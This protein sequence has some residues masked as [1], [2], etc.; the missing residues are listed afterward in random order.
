V[1]GLK[2]CLVIFLFLAVL[3]LGILLISIPL[4]GGV[5][6]MQ[7]NQSGSGT[8][9]PTAGVVKAA[10]VDLYAFA[11]APAVAVNEPYIT[12]TAFGD[13]PDG[14][15]IR[16]HGNINE[17]VGFTCDSTPCQLSLSSD[18]VVSF[19]AYT[20]VGNTSQEYSAVV[21]VSEPSVGEYT[22]TV[23]TSPPEKVYS[24]SC[25]AI[26]GIPESQ[27]PDWAGMTSNPSELDTNETLYLLA[28]SLIQ[29]GVV[30]VSACP[31]GGMANGSPDGCGMEQARKAMVA[32]Q[33]KFDLDIW[34][35]SNAIGIPPKLL[36]TL[37]M[38]ES[39]F[40][41][42]NAQYVMAEIGLA[43]INDQG[44]DVALRWDP[45]LY[46]EICS[47][48]LSDCN[49]PYLHLPE[50]L[51]AM[52]RG[53]LLNQL[54]AQCPTCKYGLNVE[55]AHTS[56]YTIARVLHANCWD[57]YYALQQ[58]KVTAASYEDYW[59]LTLVSYHSGFYCLDSAVAATV[60]AGE[61]IDWPNVSQHLICPGAALY[62]DNFWN[63]LATF[64]NKVI[65]PNP[66]ESVSANLVQES[67]LVP[68]ATPPASSASVTPAISSASVIVHVYV[69][70]N[71]NGIPD[72]SEGVSGVSVELTL[73]NG[74]N[75]Y[76]TTDG[77]GDAIFDSTGG[78]VGD[79]VKIS[80]VNLYRSQ[81]LI[82]SESGVMRV[83]F[84]FDQ[85]NLP[86]SLP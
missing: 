1:A 25:S 86:T 45:N 37:L 28:G 82:L 36:K 11:Q 76:Q 69:D 35:T 77:Q 8:P 14:V 80:L 55:L 41:P 54:N 47:G 18:S 13:V 33:N 51:R 12:F 72:P 52:V 19:Q 24:E 71:G 17:T 48:V 34:L 26:W 40:W 85:P 81:N 31:S 67:T 58:N 42:A 75:E 70:K 63:T 16:I 29:N 10:L 6:A 20:D 74:K 61:S 7:N 39:Q 38:Q 43:Q 73:P 44:A 46:Q 59:K 50:S 21:R 65:V 79:V 83:V 27:L 3:A 56:I 53:A 2:R 4:G 84:K 15:S 30:D 5:Y 22:V 32:W 68:S 9:T 60:K 64:N 78:P 62:V 66:V 49:T 23:K 57:S